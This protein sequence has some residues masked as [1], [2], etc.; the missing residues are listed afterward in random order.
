MEKSDDQATAGALH[1]RIRD[2]ILSGHFRPGERLKFADLQERYGVGVSKMREALIRLVEQG[3]VRSEPM[4]GFAVSEV[5]IGDMEDLTEARA[6]IEPMVF[7]QAI[8]HGSIAWESEVV[9]A[10]HLLARTPMY[11][12]S[13][14][15]VLNPEWVE[16][17]LRFHLQLLEGCPIRRLKEIAVLLRDGAELYRTWSQTSEQAGERDVESEHAQIT[18]AVTSR[19]AELGA[20]LLE[21][22]IR[23]TFEVM[24]LTA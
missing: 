16:N 23:K 1:L 2:D 22:H 14:E 15:R 19:D 11:D 4:I 7:S 10:H 5:S 9:A 24:Q 17:H 18:A 8:E 21:E 6:R 3:L 12:E 13:E 20:R